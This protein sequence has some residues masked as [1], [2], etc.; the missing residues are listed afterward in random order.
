MSSTQKFPVPVQLTSEQ[1]RQR[2]S[3]VGSLPFDIHLSPAVT[4]LGVELQ[5]HSSGGCR[6]QKLEGAQKR[7]VGSGDG[8]YFAINHFGL[9]SL[10]HLTAFIACCNAPLLILK[11]LWRELPCRGRLVVTALHGF[12]MTTVCCPFLGVLGT[13]NVLCVC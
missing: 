9:V 2:G 8:A 12:G 4:L 13:T 3:S 5:C 1:K 6:K 11:L 10:Y 7:V